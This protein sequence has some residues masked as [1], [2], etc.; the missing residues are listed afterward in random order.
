MGRAENLIRLENVEE[1][2]TAN[3]N[4]LVY[5]SFHRELKKAIECYAN[6]KL[7]D[8]GCGNKP[9]E[10]WSKDYV[11]EYIGCDIIQSSANKVDVISTAV[12]V[13]CTIWETRPTFHNL[14]QFQLQL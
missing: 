4:Y 13:I 5:F 8:I 10:S 2:N 14:K 1:I 9:Y 7:L 6:G 12:I 11:T 3:S